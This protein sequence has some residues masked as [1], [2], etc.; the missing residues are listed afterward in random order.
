MA[1]KTIVSAVADQV[2]NAVTQGAAVV[3]ATR[4]AVTA[5]TARRPNA[6]TPRQGAEYS[7]KW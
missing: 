7:A 4:K 5:A 3:S 1:K 6:A 2:G